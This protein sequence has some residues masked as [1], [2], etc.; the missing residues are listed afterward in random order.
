M[1]LLR[2]YLD[3][4]ICIMFADGSILEDEAG[5]FADTLE[6]TGLQDEVVQH[7]QNIVSGKSPYPNADEVIARII[8]NRDKTET[9][10]IVRDA[11]LMADSDGE[12]HASEK[13]LITD[14]LSRLGFSSEKQEEA[15][16]WGRYYIDNTYQG[17]LLF[18]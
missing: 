10:Y 16:K 6:K 15:F 1:S 5:L 3:Y 17:K 4:L 2:D 13:H 9:M 14:L 7:Y 8:N 11:F 12:I 18:S